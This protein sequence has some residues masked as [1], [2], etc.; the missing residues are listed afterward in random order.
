MKIKKAILSLA[1]IVLAAMVTSVTF[2][3]AEEEKVNGWYNSSNGRAQITD[4]SGDTEID[5]S[6]N[7]AFG[8][9]FVLNDD[10]ASGLYGE[11]DMTFELSAN[12]TKSE[13]VWISIIT[14]YNSEKDDC[15][16]T[17]LHF[18]GNDWMNI[19]S[20]GK[21]NGKDAGFSKVVEKNEDFPV[22]TSVVSVKISL[23]YDANGNTVENLY[24][25]DKQVFTVNLTE[26][27]GY[28]YYHTE[29]VGFDLFNN[30]EDVKISDISVK[31]TA[32][33]KNYRKTNINDFI[34]YGK[35]NEFVAKRLT[36][37]IDSSET[38]FAF[39]ENEQMN[40]GMFSNGKAHNYAASAKVKSFT[41]K[42]GG[43]QVGFYAW[44]KNVH[45]YVLLKTDG[46]D[47]TAEVVVNGA[48]TRT[49]TVKYA[50]KA[51]DDFGFTKK[52]ASDGISVLIAKLG[53]S[54][55]I[56][57]AAV[58]NIA[59]N[60]FIGVYGKDVKADYTNIKTT[61]FYTPYDF[62][63][64]YNEETEKVWMVSGYKADAW[65][66][67]GENATVTLN[68]DYD[69]TIKTMSVAV[70]KK[71]V[72]DPSAEYEMLLNVEK[73]GNYA[74]AAVPYFNGDG[75][76][77]IAG[78]ESFNGTN[79]LFIR[80]SDGTGVDKTISTVGEEK[81]AVSR[82]ATKFT[83][84]Y[85]G[86]TLEYTN[87]NL[88]KI[89]EYF[90]YAFAGSGTAEITD[91]TYD[92]FIS[93]K[94][95]EENGWI[96]TSVQKDDI[97]FG[98][99]GEITINGNYTEAGLTAKADQQ[100]AKAIRKENVIN[101]YV[102]DVDM[103]KVIEPSGQCQRL[104][105]V[106]WYLNDENY[107]VIFVDQWT[108]WEA[109]Q[110]NACG[111]Y[112]GERMLDSSFNDYEWFLGFADT[113]GYI[114]QQFH[115]KVI[116]NGQTIKGFIGDVMIFNKEFSKDEYDLTIYDD[117]DLYLGVFAAG[118]GAKFSNFTVRE[119]TEE[120]GTLTP[121]K[122]NRPATSREKLAAPAV[123]ISDEG[124]ASWNAVENATGYVY[125]INGGEEVET[126]ETSVS[127]NDGDEIIVKA[128]GNGETYDDSDY[129]QA[130]KYVKKPEKKGCG[131]CGGSVSVA[132]MS[133]VIAT[134]FAAA[135]VFTS[136]KKNN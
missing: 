133:A 116:K 95:Y 27:Y 114:N 83:L 65:D 131:G 68:N 5:T 17:G 42:D 102:I 127:L 53:G 134:I 60:Y 100:L 41:A 74:F 80:Y 43:F 15:L 56:E 47:F 44:Y 63:E 36:T 126:T 8:S 51:G 86:E 30:S 39:T 37:T 12:L 85:N 58:E 55:E 123:S 97:V 26:L 122:G 31:N 35:E 94:K 16:R 29:S 124:V 130:Q 49:E 92:G 79:K 25:N 107:F 118:I 14:I 61:S 111:V 38:V 87:E 105:I 70:T 46:V 13:E 2:A 120:E 4:V 66:I 98:N 88:T 20:Y 22:L 50:L 24:L 104:G 19:A 81:I 64:E 119:M 72:N 45:N 78:V 23:V 52:T 9:S 121:S 82:E 132:G 57:L 125:K 75:D 93:F 101:D 33:E 73:A 112:D 135:Y 90:G 54:E 62:S 40:A 1:I 32:S 103:V 136:K 69:G 67:S 99:D 28:Y 109:Y 129:G 128:K 11:Y 3:F 59:E 117:D 48:V 91:Y 6:G 106:P 7:T 21:L 89:S 71:V 110:L 113:A 77:V 76:Y 84:T 115:L 18:T 108:V 34:Y 96:K 10:L